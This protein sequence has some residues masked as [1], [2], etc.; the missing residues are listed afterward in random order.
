VFQLLR[1]LNISRPP[2]WLEF[3]IMLV[4]WL[5][6]RR[7]RQYPVLPFDYFWMNPTS[8]LPASQHHATEQPDPPTDQPV[9][10]LPPPPWPDTLAEYIFDP[11]LPCHDIEPGIDKSSDMQAFFSNDKNWWPQSWDDVNDDLTFG[12][13][14]AT[15][16]WFN[17]N[18]FAFSFSYAELDVVP[19]GPLLH[20]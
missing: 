9:S 12:R 17:M 14:T 16:L 19:I 15:K 20:D 2:P 18:H 8:P 7:T 3:A 11:F 13:Y 10:S 1:G 4:S 5:V 6:L